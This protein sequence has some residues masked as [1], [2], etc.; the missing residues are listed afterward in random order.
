MR[1]RNRDITGC[2][3]DVTGDVIVGSINA[4]KCSINALKCGIT[5]IMIQY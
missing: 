3:G 5:T 4:L 2:H 1:C